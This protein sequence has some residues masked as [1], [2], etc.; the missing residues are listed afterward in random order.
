[1]VDFDF[2][3]VEKKLFM[4]NIVNSTMLVHGVGTWHLR[5]RGLAMHLKQMMEGA[6]LHEMVY[7]LM[8]LR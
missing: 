4:V 2:V 1:M 5:P 7:A 6:Y 8:S 3:V